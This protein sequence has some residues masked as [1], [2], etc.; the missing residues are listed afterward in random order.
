[1]SPWLVNPII[2]ASLV[3]FDFNFDAD[4]DADADA[5]VTV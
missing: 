3:D 4:A 1:V 5:D 2:I